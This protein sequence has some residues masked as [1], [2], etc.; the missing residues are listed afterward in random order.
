MVS[1]P[2]EY[3]YMFDYQSSDILEICE[4]SFPLI[5]NDFLVESNCMNIPECSK[6]GDM[7][8]SSMAKRLERVQVRM[9]LLRNG[10][11]YD[12]FS[13]GNSRD[14]SLLICSILRHNSIPSRV[15]SGFVTFLDPIKKTEHCICEVWN[16][17][18]ERWQWID[19]WMYQIERKMNLLP[20]EYSQILSIP[21][22]CS[23]DVSPEFFIP[24]CE[25]WYRC[26]IRKDEFRLFGDISEGYHGEWFVR[27]NMIRD[28]F[29]LNKIEP[30]LNECWGKMGPENSFMDRILYHLYDQMALAMIMED[31]PLEKI[32]FFCSLTNANVVHDAYEYAYS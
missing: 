10:L 26:R 24:G 18:E 16:W 4:K 9:D 27:D 13:I 1:S 19:G 23:L 5:L 17:E 15:R 6:G 12:S 20:A 28:L 29:C 11:G 2:G 3:S 30:L 22:F 21:D 7:Y 31:T 25:A 32:D 14:I 8:I